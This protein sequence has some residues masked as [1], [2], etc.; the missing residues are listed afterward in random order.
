MP[1][2]IINPRGASGA[3]KTEFVRRIIADY[4]RENGGR[5]EP[6]HRLGREQPIGYLVPHPHGGRPLA[7]LG[8]YGGVRGGCD[9]I[10]LS[11]GGL[12]AVF[13]LADFYASIGHDVL[14]EGLLLSRERMRTATLAE[15][16]PLTILRLD[17]TLEQCIRNVIARRRAGRAAWLRIAQTVA[18]A[19]QEIEDAC[20]ALQGNAIV[21]ALSFDAA[22]SYIHGLLGVQGKAIAPLPSIIAAGRHDGAAPWQVQ[23]GPS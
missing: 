12:E 6:V 16:H 15:R 19:D 22:I 3:G 8:H 9:T 20:A 11:D 1:G 17:T 10:S 14:L 21:M 18:V 4:K 2:I 23:A 7:V 5:L 13:R